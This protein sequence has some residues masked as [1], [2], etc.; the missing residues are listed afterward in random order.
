MIDGWDDLVTA[1]SYAMHV[2][3]WSVYRSLNKRLAEIALCDLRVEGDLRVLD[4]AC[5]TGATLEA[6]LQGL[7]FESE[8]L[9]VDAAAAMVE[10]AEQ[11]L[12]DPR[13]SWRVQRAEALLQQPVGPFDLISCG[14]AFWH[15]DS[16]VHQPLIDCL[17][18]GGRLVFNLPAAQC[19]DGELQAHP[20]QAAVANLLAAESDIFP[21][22]HPRFDRQEF[23]QLCRRS[24]L[25]CHW[26]E[27]LWQGP[28]AALVDLLRIPAMAELLAPSL[29]RA[30]LEAL[31]EAAAERVDADQSVS[32]AWFLA[33]VERP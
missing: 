30:Q 33:R 5:G 15:L 22:L 8:I 12:P 4:L 31:V 7:P 10:Y 3:R 28:Q 6:L 27:Q 26:S 17:A 1:E 11:R 21:A 9:A 18:P 29:P 32:V 13:V 2:D 24:G 14:A 25:T 23:A 16:C 19:V 20:I